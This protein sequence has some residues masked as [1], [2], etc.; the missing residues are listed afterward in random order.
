M[1]GVAAV[2]ALGGI[3]LSLFIW[4]LKQRPLLPLHDPRLGYHS[5]EAEA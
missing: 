2:V 1:D 5:L 3:W 4:R